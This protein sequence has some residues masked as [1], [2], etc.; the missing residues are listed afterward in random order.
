MD[1]IDER[2]LVYVAL[3]VVCSTLAVFTGPFMAA[4]TFIWVLASIELAY[5]WMLGAA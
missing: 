3:L 5:W 2:A 1:V 4:I